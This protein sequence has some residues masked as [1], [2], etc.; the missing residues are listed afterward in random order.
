[1][2]EKRDYYE[3]LG[4]SR[5]AS[6]EDLKKAYRRLARQYHPDVN[7][8]ADAE[9]RFKEISE[10]YEVLHDPEKRAAYDRFGHAGV[11]GAGGFGAYPGF[12][13]GGLSDIFEEF[14]GFGPRAAAR[15]GPVRGSDLRVQLSL[16]FEEAVFGAEKEIEVSRLEQCP[17]CGGS[18][19]EPGS[20]PRRCTEC[21]G[22]GEVRRV[23]QTLFG[24]F[25]NVTTCP[26]C[27]GRGEVVSTPC[28]QC[29]GQQRVHQTKRLAVDIP[30]GV[31]DGTQIRLGGEGEAGLH[32][33]PH[34]DLYVLLRVQ[35]HRY[36]RRQEN[37]ILLDV[38]ISFVQAALGDRIKVPTLEGEE[39]LTIP[40]GTQTGSSF[41]LRGKGVPILR[42]SGR[43]DQI[44]TV[45][46]RTPTNLTP[47]QKKLLKELGESLG[48]EVTPQE[49]RS[50]FEKVKDAFRV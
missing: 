22:R 25:V 41:R 12:G 21:N 27:G 16:S 6:D 32:G 1:M 7:K 14:F 8:S 39:A 45:H 3:V 33:G 29:R 11:Q 17:N 36:F 47:Q 49:S 13:F 43:G 46:I 26:R 42:Q 19:A 50:F 31:D 18:G 15:Q 35:H 2:A 9:A 4:V 23:Q 24:S 40:A 48:Y 5:A 44:V 10:A 34:G 20:L 38:N 28:T 37:D 30:G